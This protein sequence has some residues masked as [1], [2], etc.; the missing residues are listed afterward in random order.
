MSC[1]PRAADEDF[2]DSCDQTDK[3]DKGTRELK[4]TKN[5]QMDVLEHRKLAK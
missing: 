4:V 5:D 2:K 1:H 3:I